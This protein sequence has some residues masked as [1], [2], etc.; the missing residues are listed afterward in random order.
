MLEEMVNHV[1]EKGSFTDTCLTHN[2]YWDIEAHSLDHKTHFEEVI[3]VY[4]ISFFAIYLI[5]PVS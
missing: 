2:D 4:Y 3:D 5:V 1:T